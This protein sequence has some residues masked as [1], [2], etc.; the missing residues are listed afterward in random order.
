MQRHACILGVQQAIERSPAGLHPLRL[1]ETLQIPYVW[2]AVDAVAQKL[3]SRK[4]LNSAEV[5]KLVCAVLPCEADDQITGPG[6]RIPGLHQRVGSTYCNR[7]IRPARRGGGPG[8]AALAVDPTEYLGRTVDPVRGLT[9]RGAF[10]QVRPDGR[11]MLN[12]QDLDRCIEQN[13]KG[14]E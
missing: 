8:R 12:I 4:R 10:P 13:M 6:T 9:K 3:V 14:A 2:A 5:H 1:L 7:R 11:V